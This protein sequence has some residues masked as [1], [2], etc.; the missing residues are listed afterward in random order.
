MLAIERAYLLSAEVPGVKVA[1]SP[2]LLKD[3]ASFKAVW[4]AF[5]LD[6]TVHS[7][8][9]RTLRIRHLARYRRLRRS[10][11]L[12]AIIAGVACVPDRA[13]CA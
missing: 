6:H 2:E 5:A 7:P 13:R 9:L 3:A 12:R 1:L 4:I 11:L 10:V 8:T